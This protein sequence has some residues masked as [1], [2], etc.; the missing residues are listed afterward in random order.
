MTHS[1][2]FIKAPQKIRIDASTVCQLKCPSCPTASGKIRMHLGN[3][4]LSFVDFK[5]LMDKNKS[6][7][8][9]ELSNWGELFLNKEIDKIIRYAYQ[10]NVA[11]YANNGANLNNVSEQVIETLVKYKFRSMT[12]SIDGA[13]HRTYSEYRRN[14]NFDRVIDNI[15]LINKYKAR[16]KSIY[17]RLT[18]QFIAFGHNEHEISTARQMANELNMK[19]YCKLSWGDLYDEGDFEPVRDKGLIRKESGLGAADREEYQNLYNEEYV[20]R[21]S[22]LDMWHSPQLNYNG[23]LLGCCINYHGNYG[24]VFTE[25]LYD[26]VNNEKMVYAREMLMG[27]RPARQDIPCTKCKVFLSYNKS[28]NWI[29]PDELIPP[30]FPDRKHI[31]LENKILKRKGFRLM[32]GIWKKMEKT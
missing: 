22:C 7:A 4:Y 11:L 15:K 21:D 20:M 1:H 5:K 30:S 25:G 29:R 19:F 27:K 13:S 24:N 2:Q 18:W 10:K 32:A 26:A 16:Y 12:C 9:I 17:P 3:G 6:V 23:D 31:F 8:R 14:G 28:K